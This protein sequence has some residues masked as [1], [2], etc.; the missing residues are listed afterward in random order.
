MFFRLNRNKVCLTFLCFFVL[1]C[2]TT[3]SGFAVHPVPT[4]ILIRKLSRATAGESQGGEFKLSSQLLAQAST[5]AEATTNKSTEVNQAPEKPQGL[6]IYVNDLGN[7]LSPSDSQALQE[8]LQAL[9]QAG[10]AQVSVLTL[11][12][13]SR[14]LAEFGPEIMNQWGIQHAGRKD[15]LLIL[16]NADAV[17]SHKH[18]GRIFVATGYQI[19]GVL[20][21]AKIGRILDE[22]AVPAFEQDR[23]SE[24]IV[25]TTLALCGVLEQ[26]PELKNGK[27]A[28]H[29]DAPN[30]FAIIGMLLALFFMSKRLQRRS[31]GSYWGGGPDLGGGYY[32][33]GFSGGNDSGGFE[34]GFG[35]G[36]DASGGGGTER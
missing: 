26:S 10:I 36:D 18:R 33:G 14:E 13:T 23:P 4:D 11:P 30:W 17:R 27:S 2:R 32:G 3:P 29:K 6:N 20:P 24:G 7:L 35:G 9:D 22:F 28:P 19:E 16:V 34:G 25:Q 21:D 15:G 12:A 1:A 31:R 8:R 5:Q